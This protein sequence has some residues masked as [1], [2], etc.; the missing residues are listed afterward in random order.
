MFG[1]FSRPKIIIPGAR[2]A[3]ATAAMCPEKSGFDCNDVVRSLHGVSMII[4]KTPDGASGKFRRAGSVLQDLS[5][6]LNLDPRTGNARVPMRQ[7]ERTVYQLNA[8][9]ES[10]HK[11]EDHRH[12]PLYAALAEDGTIDA[13]KKFS[14]RFADMVQNYPYPA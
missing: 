9:T 8:I 10:P 5:V 1:V 12:D 2:L 13:L 4:F 7:W 14:A 11:Y 6:N 3:Y